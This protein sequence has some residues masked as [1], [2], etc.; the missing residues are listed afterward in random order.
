MVFIM[1][2]RQ[3]QIVRENRY[4]RAFQRQADEI[5]HL[6]VNTDLPWVDIAIQIDR[7]R[8]EAARLFPLKM[9][10]FEWIYMRRFQRLWTQWRDA[11][12]YRE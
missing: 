9:T 6:I 8:T 4:L 10:L 3:D 5:C 7:L 12:Q 2:S 11:V 1:E